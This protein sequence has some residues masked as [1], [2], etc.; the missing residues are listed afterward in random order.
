MVCIRV[1]FKRC[2]VDPVSVEE[3]KKKTT[4]VVRISNVNELKRARSKHGR[5]VAAHVGVVLYAKIRSGS[6]GFR[7]QVR[8]KEK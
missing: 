8:R 1:W 7:K 6:R 4:S 2:F 5:G 3:G